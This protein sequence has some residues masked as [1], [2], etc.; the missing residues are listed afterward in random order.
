MSAFGRWLFVALVLSFVT[1]ARAAPDATRRGV[2]DATP[3]AAPDLTR[4][5]TPDTTPR[6]PDAP[7][8]VVTITIDGAPQNVLILA[9]ATNPV[10]AVVMFPGGDGQIG[11]GANGSIARKGNFLIRTRDKWLARGFLFVAVDAAAARASSRG[12]RVGPAN[13][14]AIA[15]IVRAVR[16]RTSAPIWLLGTSAGAPAAVAGAASL[17]AGVIR[18]VAISS[19]LS[20]PGPHDSVFDAPLARIGVPVLIQIHQQDGCPA[21]PPANAIRIKAALSSAPVAEVQQFSGGKPPRSAQCDAFS[22]HG[23]Y[24]IEDEVVTATANWMMAH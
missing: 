18:G 6:V 24:G 23:F 10:A 4:R 9:P 21:T 11:I 16:Q 17:P 22:E 2:P 5:A 12:D 1:T 13:Q 14:R 15:E 7:G 8:S 3:R 19:P 20:K